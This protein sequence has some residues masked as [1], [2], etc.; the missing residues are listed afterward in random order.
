[1]GKL[2]GVTP[3]LVIAST[4]ALDGL[5][6]SSELGGQIR[7]APYHGQ[8]SSLLKLSLNCPYCALQ[9]PCYD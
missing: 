3:K 1:V 7:A 5:D 2:H 8:D 4:G 6:C 9:G